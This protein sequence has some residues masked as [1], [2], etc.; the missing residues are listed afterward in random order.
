M[1]TTGAVS[2][3]G[4]RLS[5]GQTCRVTVCVPWQPLASFTRTVMEV[6]GLTETE[7]VPLM[8]PVLAL[9]ERPVGSVPLVM[10]QVLYGAVPPLA[11]SVCE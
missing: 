8:T 3:A 11:A 6:A 1:P 7:G 9:S 2:V 10:V 4:A 5:T